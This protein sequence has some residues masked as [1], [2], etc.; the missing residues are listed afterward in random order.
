M[1]KYLMNNM[2]MFPNSYFY[3]VELVIFIYFIMTMVLYSLYDEFV[4]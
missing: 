1:R 4:V 3:I 2:S